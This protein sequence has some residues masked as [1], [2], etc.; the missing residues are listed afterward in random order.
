MIFG[1]SCGLSIWFVKSSRAS[2]GQPEAL[3]FIGGLR[4]IV[5]IIY[6]IDFNRYI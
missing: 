3:D 2:G 5:L 4:G 6:S 1:W